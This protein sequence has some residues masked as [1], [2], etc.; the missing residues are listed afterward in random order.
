M[1]VTRIEGSFGGFTA[2][3][4]TVPS[5]ETHVIA[6][7]AMRNRMLGGQGRGC[8]RIDTMSIVILERG[9]APTSS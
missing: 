6:H 7:V 8:Q 1:S 5:N 2:R 9:Q 3:H 4:D